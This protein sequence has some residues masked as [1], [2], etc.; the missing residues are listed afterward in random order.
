MKLRIQGNSIRLRLQQEEAAALHETGVV[1]ECVQLG[2]EPDEPFHYC[3]ATDPAGTAGVHHRQ[4]RLTV[5]IP[6]DWAAE[7]ADSTR[8]GHDFEVLLRN[9]V[10]IRVLIETDLPCAHKQPEKDGNMESL[11]TG[12]PP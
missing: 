7:L 11:S 12:P 1:E 3:L 10:F 9:G 5:T 4:G 6:P 8:N 2:P